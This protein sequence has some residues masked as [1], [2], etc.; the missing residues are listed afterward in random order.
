MKTEIL[1]VPYFVRVL[2]INNETAISA[3]YINFYLHDIVW[4]IIIDEATS[5]R[6]YILI[7]W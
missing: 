2:R 6:I 4:K 1:K 5:I 3:K 7:D